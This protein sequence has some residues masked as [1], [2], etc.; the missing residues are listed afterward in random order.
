MKESEN[1]A[2]NMAKFWERKIRDFNQVKYIK[3]E[4]DSLLVKDDEIKNTWR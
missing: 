2:Y 1:N 4:T 3:D